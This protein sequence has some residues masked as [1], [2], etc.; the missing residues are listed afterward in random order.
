GIGDDDLSKS[1]FPQ[2]PARG[3]V[4]LAHPR[5]VTIVAP[6]DPN[7]A[8]LYAYADALASSA[9][10]KTVGGEYGVRAITASLHVAGVQPITSDVSLDDVAAYITQSTVDQSPSA[11]PDGRTIYLVYLP[12]G[13]NAGSSCGVGGS[14]H[15]FGSLG[16][17]FAVVHRCKSA[18]PI[19]ASHEVIEAATDPT[20][21][22]Y[23]IAAAKP[24]PWN[25]S[26][27]AMTDGEV[28]DL[29][30]GEPTASENGF[31]FDRSWSNQAATAGHDPCVPAQVGP[32]FYAYAKHD[33]YAVSAGASV[34]VTIHGTSSSEAPWAINA[35][36]V[37]RHGLSTGAGFVAQLDDATIDA[38]GTT[39]LR[40]EAP[41]DAPSGTWALVHVTSQ[42]GAVKRFWPVGF[43][44]P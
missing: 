8:G 21:D 7:A 26:V 12:P 23:K 29:C 44:V 36:I 1:R 43:Y 17:V 11:T 38:G 39:T 2:I 41:S 19:I 18:P 33:W 22:G 10:W 3:H 34:G 5:L 16:D 28:G 31:S 6:N 30:E 20:N 25:G 14:H 35:T 13:V 27:W 32:L 4:V 9:W 37:S 24:D 42:S 15:V 40:V